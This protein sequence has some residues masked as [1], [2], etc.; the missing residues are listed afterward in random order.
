[1][2][3]RI[4]L[5]QEECKKLFLEKEV[6]IF[7]TGVDAQEAQKELSQYAVV[8]A[9]IDNNRYGEGNKFHGKNI[10][11]LEQF[12]NQ[13]C[14]GQQIIVASYRYAMEICKQ[15]I[16]AGLVPVKDFFVWD[17]MHLFHY[18]ISTRKYIDFLNDKWRLHEK[19]NYANQ[20][21][22]PFDNRHDLMSVIY[23]YC[24]NYFAEK[25]DAVIYAY[26]RKGSNYS[27]ASKVI[28]EIYKSFNVKNLI[29]TELSEY[30]QE[31]ADQLCDSVWKTLSTWEDWKNITVYGICFGTTIVRDFMREYIPDF[32]LKSKK[33]YLFLKKRMRTIVFWYHYIFENDIK[34]VLLADGVTWDGYI[35]DIA[36]T[37][38]IPTYALCYKMA[39][40]TLD[41]CDRAPYPFFKSMW[42]QLTSEEQEYGI[43]WAKEHIESRLRGGTEEVFN[44]NKENFTFAEKKKGTR[45]LAQNDK[46]KI[47]ICPHI[48][49][50]DTFWCGEQI[51]DNNNFSWLCHLGELSEITPEYDWYLK[52][53]PAAKR[54]DFIIID[55]ILKKYTKIKKIASDVSPFQMKEEGADFA[56][57]VCGTIGHEYPEIGIQ[58]IN[59][60]INP[61]TSFEFTWNPK[62]K[63]EYDDLILHLDRLEKKVDE[64]ELYQFYSLNYLFYNWEYVSYRTLFFENPLLA[65]SSLELQMYG[66]KL[67]TWKYEEYMKEWTQEKHEK[68]LSQLGE[69]FQKLDEWKPDILYRKEKTDR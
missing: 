14:N 47:I 18:D 53:H 38:G 4:F 21:L 41:Y 19:S 51:F 63:E 40:M 57:T 17:E 62:T 60:G 65:M 46:I 32:D 22:V 12:F 56:L 1:M 11:S 10:I 8:L 42:T 13:R 66:K 69:V 24:A 26:F 28:K 43:K 39:K 59:A 36:I 27:N 34:V 31:E 5:N 68:I 48:F 6:F 45:V 25:H 7:G 33:M 64:T 61:H 54:R 67:G 49:E 44:N 16:E 55:M 37:K 23:A 50:E 35:R 20:I 9:Y 2:D 29:N 30:Q 15:L 3:D 52:M 58:V